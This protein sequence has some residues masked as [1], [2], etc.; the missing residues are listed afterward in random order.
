M[1][2]KLLLHCRMSF[3]YT[4]WWFDFISAICVCV[5]VRVVWMRAFFLRRSRRWCHSAFSFS[6]CNLFSYCLEVLLLLFCCFARFVVLAAHARRAERHCVRVRVTVCERVRG[7][8]LVCRWISFGIL[9]QSFYMSLVHFSS[10]AFT[11]PMVWRFR[12]FG[13]WFHQLS[14]SSNELYLVR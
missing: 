4:T 2:V 7:E 3:R 8:Y 14:A 13:F 10:A 1:T 11:C 5:C 6:M 12:L 9:L